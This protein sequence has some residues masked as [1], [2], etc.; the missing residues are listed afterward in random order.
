LEGRKSASKDWRARR[1]V[2][3]V[4]VNEEDDEDADEDEDD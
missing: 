4:N 1:N 3:N 2:R